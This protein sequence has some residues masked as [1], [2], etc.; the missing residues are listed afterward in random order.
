MRQLILGAALA[1]LLPFA[2]QAQDAAAGEKAFAPCKACH[3]FG[4]NGVGPDLKGVI[5]R[6]AGT[7]E[8]YNYSAAM[9][10]SG[11]TWDE[12]TFRDYIHDPKAKVPGTKMIYAGMKDDKKVSDLIAY[13]ETQK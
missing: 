5:G 1:A 7:H 13:L 2:A 4:K 12:S 6:K 9:K 11:L 8:G 10:N 3:A